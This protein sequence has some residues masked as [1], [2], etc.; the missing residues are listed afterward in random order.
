[1][2]YGSDDADGNETAKQCDQEIQMDEQPAASSSELDP[3][4][5]YAEEV[6][7]SFF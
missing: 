3:A 1:M 7:D 5:A 4:V 6:E 2:E